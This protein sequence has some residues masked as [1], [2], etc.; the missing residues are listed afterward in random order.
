M[1]SRPVIR[2]SVLCLILAAS[3]AGNG[4]RILPSPPAVPDVYAMPPAP[5]GA[6]AELSA[7]VAEACSPDES[8]FLLL[9]RNDEALNWRLALIDHA[10][11]SIDTQYFLWRADEAG[12][13]LIDRLIKAA[14]RGV[15]V[16]LLVDDF[17]IAGSDREIAA[18]CQHP[19]FDIKIFNPGY[20]RRGKLGGI[21]EFLLRF[22]QLNRRM[23]NKL[24]VVDSRV[25]IVGGRNISNSY[26]GLSEK[27]NF[28]DL[29]VL[30]VGP[31]IEEI[32]HAFDDYWNN[33][34]SY[35]GA[36]MYAR[37]KPQDAQ[38]LRNENAE[39]LRQHRDVLASYPLES[40]S[41]RAELLRLP[42]R[43]VAGK[44]HFLQDEPVRFGD[45]E[46]RL[47]DMLELLAE[48]NHEELIVVTPYLIPIRARWNDLDDLSAE[49][50]D[51]KILT[52]SMTST[53][54]TIAHSHYKK[55]RRRLLADGAELYEFSGDPSAA[56]RE[57]S[58][59]PPVRAGFIALHIK[60]MVGDR[61]RC[62]IGSLNHDPRAITINTENGLYIESAA[63]SAQLAEYLD[64]LMAP[65]NAWRVYVN[66]KN[67]VRW[68]SGAGVVSR[69]PARSFSQRV[70]DFFYSLLPIESQL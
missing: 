31:V 30:T 59:V 46:L 45:E 50:V 44:A 20:V 14:D 10:T 40:K 55:Y 62:F 61:E 65:D 9:W 23:H 29:D 68:E 2:I 22:R 51:V 5:S 47:V 56:V 6:L 49:G 4:C 25:A 34:L 32:S 69:Q 41:W 24:L 39:Y 60:A 16:R 67:K 13:L 3:L 18:L 27:Y 28:S 66:E 37:A 57:A 52:A 58:D 64:S 12:R 17:Y 21:G 19:Y 38:H 33:D 70:S 63:L 26:F 8:G 15:R 48:P 11:S 54:Q 35:P 42:S 1:Q 53:N 36:A 7:K 43:L